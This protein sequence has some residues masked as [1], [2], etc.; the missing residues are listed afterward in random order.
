MNTIEAPKE[1][2]YGPHEAKGRPFLKEGTWLFLM[3]GADKFYAKVKPE[4]VQ[5]ALAGEMFEAHHVVTA[6]MQGQGMLL[7]P[8]VATVDPW[9]INGTLISGLSFMHPTSAAKMD[10]TVS[11]AF[12]PPTIITARATDIPVTGKI[13]LG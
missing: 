12:N 5:K 8:L 7:A 11:K 13:H 10:D 4:D 2:T 1:L 6:S 9:Y 3:V